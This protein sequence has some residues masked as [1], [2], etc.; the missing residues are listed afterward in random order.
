MNMP[1]SNYEQLKVENLIKDYILPN[2]EALRV[3]NG[4]SFELH[5]G[6]FLVILG[7]NG[8]GKSTLVKILTGLEKPTSGKIHIP[9]GVKSIGY[10]PQREILIPWKTV[11]ENLELVCKVRDVDI[12]TEKI[13][14]I[15][16]S[17]ELGEF[18]E[19]YPYQLSI[20]MRQKINV[21]RAILIAK[22]WLILDEPFSAVDVNMR[23]LLNR[24]T[25][26]IVWAEDYVSSNF[27]ENLAE[28]IA[29]LRKLKE[30][31][32]LGILYITHSV[33]EA[34]M[35]A[36][37][38]LILTKRPTKVYD[39]IKIEFRDEEGKPIVDPLKR[40]AHPKFSEYFSKVWNRF[41]EVFEGKVEKHE[42][43]VQV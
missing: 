34:I 39:E 14:Q 18:A 29:L 30:K 7:P 15:L 17:V 42:V 25:R 13:K 36:D 31:N 43:G 4:L 9:G 1:I 41:M 33:D 28:K 19:A 27:S 24:F 38:I 26:I 2:G 32:E 20:G 40:K 23:L 5:T 10:A 12:S 3:L 21:L 35:M 22:K 11:L 37:R 8:C 6:E 16:E